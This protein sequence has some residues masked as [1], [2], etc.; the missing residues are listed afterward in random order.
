MNPRI[1]SALSAVAGCA[2][3]AASLSL[4]TASPAAAF[5]QETFGCRLSPGTVLTYK[6]LCT[7]SKPSSRYNAAFAVQNTSGDYTYSWAIAGDYTSI[8]GGCTATS[9]TC[10]V[11]LPGSSTDSTVSVTVTY[12][13]GGQTATRTA[14][15]FTF[16]YCG[17]IYC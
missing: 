1:R 17:T 7:N 6:T 11:A 2:L 13:Q 15:A 3:A 9:S 14:H 5:G 10:A 12:S 4:A 16:M 8:V